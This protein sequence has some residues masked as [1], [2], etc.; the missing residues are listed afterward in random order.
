[1]PSS[2]TRLIFH[3]VFGTKDRCPLIPGDLAPELHSYLAGIVKARG[4]SPILVGGVPDHVHA[5][6]ALHPDNAVSGV[7][8]DMK[9]N[10]SRWMKERAPDRGAF[11]WQEGYGAFSV[12]PRGIT[13]ARDYI[14]RQEEHHRDEPF[15]VELQRFLDAYGVEYDARYL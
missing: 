13:K 2:Y 5:L 12:D 1:M 14:A 10:S 8:R 15:R 7:V 9:A 4:G 6:V 3:I 11:T